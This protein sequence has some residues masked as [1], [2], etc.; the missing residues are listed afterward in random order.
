M[1]VQENTQSA[2]EV[3]FRVFDPL[4]VQLSIDRSNVQHMKLSVR[5]VHPYVSCR[6]WVVFFL[7]YQVSSHCEEYLPLSF[8]NDVTLKSEI[9]IL[10]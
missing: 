9:I 2:G 5:L 7:S 6:S 4:T 3:V 1:I 10:V 8:F